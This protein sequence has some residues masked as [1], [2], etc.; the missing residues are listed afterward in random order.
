MKIGVLLPTFR[1]VTSD[2]L[3]AAR[4][5]AD[6]GLDGVFAYDHLWPMGR[7]DRPSFAPF[8]VLARVAL[9]NPSLIVGPLVAR[10]GL[11]SPAAL[12]E[13]FRTL[14]AVAPTRVV[15]PLG[16]GDKLSEAENIAYGV[17]PATPA[18]RREDLRR[19]AESL[20]EEM[21]VWI[22]AGAAATN[23]IARE[24]GATL[25]VWN[26]RAEVVAELGEAGPVNWAG[27][28]TDDLHTQLDTLSAAG[29]TWAVFSPTVDVVHLGAWRERPATSK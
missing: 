19:V 6:A 25:N 3:A 12:I 26:K 5:A 14:A 20:I 11:V 21:D 28:A 7:P 13:Q 4:L 23:E 29:A 9:E 17:P 15:A 1:D 8:P 22:G 18:V 10:I 2:A 27:N 24:V 16:T